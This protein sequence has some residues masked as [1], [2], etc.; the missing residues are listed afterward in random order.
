[1]L[2]LVSRQ[3]S[4]KTNV[5]AIRC[6][7]NK[8]QIVQQHLPC[9]LADFPCK[10]LGLPL[11]LK[12]LKKEVIQPIIDK[13]ADLLPGWKADLINRAGRKIHVQFVLTLSTIIFLAMALDLPTWAHKV[14]DKIRSY[15]WRGHREAKGD[16]CLVG[17]DMVCRPIKMGG[18]GI[19]YLKMLGWALKTPWL[20]PK[21]AE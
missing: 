13:M 11:A 19:S 8:P 20:W 12:K 7:E 3:I 16:H 5:L 6:G 10:Y 14:I 1:V 9:P 17:W 18:L 4:K 21:K 15:F 2:H